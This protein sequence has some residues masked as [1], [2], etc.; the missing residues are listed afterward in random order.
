MIAMANRNPV[1][2]FCMGLSSFG[3]ARRASQPLSG[4]DIVIYFCPRVAAGRQP[5]AALLNAFGV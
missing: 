1:A 3:V 4:L 5:W 2:Q